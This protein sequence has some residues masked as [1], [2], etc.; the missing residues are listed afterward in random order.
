MRVL[1][2][3][4][5]LLG[6]GGIIALLTLAVAV[7]KPAGGHDLP[8]FKCVICLAE[9]I[10]NRNPLQLIDL[11][12]DSLYQSFHLPS[13]V[14]NPYESFDHSTLSEERTLIFYSGDDLISRRFWVDLPDSVKE[15][16]FILYGGIRDWY[17]RLLF[18][19]LPLNPQVSDTG[20][21]NRVKQLS[22]FYSGQ[23]EFTNDFTL[24][25]YYYKD[26]KNAPWPKYNRVGS[27]IRRGC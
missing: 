6:V 21:V 18:P 5:K 26:L 13:A 19:K 11:R 20:M 7:V 16:S 17:E 12:S 24:L 4:Q 8:H 2:F 1:T 23:P 3:N 14:S 9:Q 10:K 22:E 27:M 15:R 25:D